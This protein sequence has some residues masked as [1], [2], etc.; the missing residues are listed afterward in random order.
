MAAPKSL[1][2]GS[3][4]GPESLFLQLKHC[5]N[6]LIIGGEA[7]AGL[8][9]GLLHLPLGPQAL[10]LDGRGR[11]EEECLTK[12]GWWGRWLEILLFHQGNCDVF[13]ILF[14]IGCFYI[15]TQ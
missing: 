5:F 2:A 3:P 6:N 15:L 12:P 4:A 14:Q 1:W 10:S 9:W 7:G 11:A 8:P 13:I